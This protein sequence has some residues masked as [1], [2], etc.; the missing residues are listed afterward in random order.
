MERSDEGSG[1]KQIA[2]K[3]NEMDTREGK[4]DIADN[5]MSGP[6]H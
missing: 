5:V 2:V 4:E 1:D 3:K 6:L